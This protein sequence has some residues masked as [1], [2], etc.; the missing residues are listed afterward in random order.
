M[1]VRLEG[2]C[3]IVCESI[4][5]LHWRIEVSCFRTAVDWGGG[6]VAPTVESLAAFPL[7]WWDA[8]AAAAVVGVAASGPSSP[9]FRA[10]PPPVWL[11][12]V[13][14]LVLLLRLEQEQ[15]ADR[16]KRFPSP[17]SLV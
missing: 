16:S 3:S 1:D 2:R 4:S 15:A 9:P 11:M 8:A 13:L 10:R 12:L 14:R 17:T 7:A 6:T 5:G